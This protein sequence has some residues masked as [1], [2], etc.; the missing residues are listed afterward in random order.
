MKLWLVMLK[1]SYACFA[2]A[3][4]ASENSEK[5]TSREYLV[6]STRFITLYE[7]L[8]R[9]DAC[10]DDMYL[11]YGCVFGHAMIAEDL[12]GNYTVKLDSKTK[13]AI[14]NLCPLILELKQK[15]IDQCE[16]TYKKYFD[17]RS[18]A[19]NSLIENIEQASRKN[20]TGIDNS[21]AEHYARMDCDNILDLFEET[22]GLVFEKP[23]QYYYKEVEKSGF[24]IR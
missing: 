14:Q 10:S 17:R 18:Y 1:K 12:L 19:Y 7:T 3:S 6:D 11:T 9:K 13:K 2:L 22:M 23:L 8:N 4:I 24:K 15:D 21:A 16:N 5:D 20:K